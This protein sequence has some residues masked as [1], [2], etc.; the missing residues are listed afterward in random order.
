MAPSSPPDPEELRRGVARLEARGYRVRLG[1]HVEARDG[2]LA[3]PDEARLED[4]HGMFADREVRAV[5]CARGGS[6]AIRL[7]PR[8]DWDLLRAHP[9]PFL[10]YSDITVLALGMLARV[11][12]PS[13]FA[14]MVATELGRGC[15]EECLDLALEL[16]SSVE[17]RGLLA[18]S[19]CAHAEVL[20]EGEAEGRLV[21]GTLSLAAATIGT[22]CRPDTRGAILFL[23]DTGESPAQVERY[24]RQFALAGLLDEVS[25]FLIGVARWDGD[26]ERYLPLARVYGDVLRPFG[27]PALFNWPLG[28]LPSP[29]TLPLGRRARLDATARSL[30]LLEAGVGPAPAR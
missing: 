20:V 6:G 4:L 30:V 24:M 16:V 5:W 3:G 15:S 22:D 27:R 25:G 12:L 13:F 18:D 14:P 28:H 23:E 17:P 10:G 9:K 29:M 2:H 26:P 1:R 21:G 7:L 19:R 11:G 8:L